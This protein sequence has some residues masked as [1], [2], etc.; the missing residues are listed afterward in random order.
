M[1]PHARCLILLAG[2]LRGALSANFALNHYLSNWGVLSGC[3]GVV[4]SLARPILPPGEAALL[5]LVLL[6]H[7]GKNECL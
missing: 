2:L 3:L 1:A 7:A 5:L 4:E 6:V